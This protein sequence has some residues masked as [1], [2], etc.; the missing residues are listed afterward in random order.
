MK[1]GRVVTHGLE[2]LR[3][4]RCPFY[5]DP[6]FLTKAQ[7]PANWLQ[8]ARI[9]PRQQGWKRKGCVRALRKG[10][11]KNHPLLRECVQV[12]SQARLHIVRGATDMIRPKRIYCD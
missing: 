2:H 9:P 5:H 10:L 12:G 8:P 11:R 3:E 1:P 7:S 6:R 4:R